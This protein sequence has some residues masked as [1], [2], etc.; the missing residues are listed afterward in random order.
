L[1]FGAYLG[2][3]THAEAI[4]LALLLPCG[5]AS[6]YAHMACVS[7]GLEILVD[8][9]VT[10]IVLA[11][12]KLRGRLDL[13]KTF[14]PKAMSAGLS[15]SLTQAIADVAAIGLEVAARRR[16]V[17]WTPQAFIDNT[18]A[19]VVFVV[20]LLLRR[21]SRFGVAEEPCLVGLA[22][23]F[24]LGE[25]NPFA[26]RTGLS[27]VRKILVS[28]A[29]TIV[30]FAIAGLD[31]WEHRAHTGGPAS[32]GAGRGAFLAGTHPSGLTRSA[33]ARLGQ[34]FVHLAI[35]IIILAVTKLRVGL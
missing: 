9:T 26:R 27:L 32:P 14:L 33:I 18:I 2:A 12:A 34:G 10:V 16:R 1:L 24:A 6:A 3:T 29:V 5:F 7:F 28:L 25:T 22:N 13:S 21:G 31:T 35:T 20:A 11:V 4:G 30:V 15:T 17:T 8:A 23:V 19:V